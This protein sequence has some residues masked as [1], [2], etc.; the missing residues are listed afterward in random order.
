M[1]EQGHELENVRQA[2]S[3][4][5]YLHDLRLERGVERERL[6]LLLG[7][8]E[9]LIEAIEQGDRAKLPS[10]SYILGIAK[11]YATHFKVSYENMEA[12]WRAE[13]DHAVSGFKDRLPRNRFIAPRR[14][15]VWSVRLSLGILFFLVVFGYLGIQLLFALMPVQIRL[16]N[17]PTVSQDQLLKISGSLRGKPKVLFLNNRRIQPENQEFATEVWL[18]P[19]P[20]N[21]RIVAENYSGASTTVERVVVYQE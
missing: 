15:W 17:L 19:G 7:V 9:K 6:A 21:I 12:L 4:L 10:D 2:T 5:S 8:P 18:A 14:A 11:K 1:A 16:K 13:T 20:N 3:L